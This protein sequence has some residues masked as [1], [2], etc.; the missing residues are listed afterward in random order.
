[1]FASPYQNNTVNINERR[2]YVVKPEKIMRMGYGE[3]YVLTAA[4]GELAHLILNDE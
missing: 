1:L 3:A 4:R 2:E